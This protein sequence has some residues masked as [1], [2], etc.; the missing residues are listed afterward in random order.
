MV[1]IMVM[2]VMARKSLPPHQLPVVLLEAAV[3]VPTL[4]NQIYQGES[5]V[6]C[7]WRV[8]QPAS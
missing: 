5:S 3:A 1:M 4:Q 2:M 7:A 8:S 6:E